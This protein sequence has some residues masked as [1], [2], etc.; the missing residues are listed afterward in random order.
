MIYNKYFPGAAAI[1]FILLL[2]NAGCARKISRNLNSDQTT[3]D[4]V[5][6][7]LIGNSFS[8]NATRFLPQLASEG[9]HGLVIGRAE[10]GSCS[11]QRHWESVVAAEADSTSKKGKPYKG[12]SLRM[13]LSEG[14]WDIVTIQQYSM[15][16][17]DTSTYSPFAEKLV[18]FIKSIQPNAEVVFHQTWAYRSDATGFGLISKGRYAKSS[19]EMWQKISTASEK[20]SGNLGIRVI[21]TGEAFWKVDSHKKWGYKKDENYNFKN[22]TYPLLPNQ[23]YSLHV[24]YNWGKAELPIK[25][26]SHHAS[27]AG[28]YL[29]GLVWYSF[30]F[31]ESPANLQ[32]TPSEVSA[33]F[34]KFLKVVAN[35]T[36]RN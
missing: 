26:D 30:L 35:S 33:P 21:P 36:L 13:L 20:I 3:R 12:K 27:V 14:R 2:L 28:C 8:Q 9:G 24:G 22:P 23:D 11:F 25:F 1:F 34:G 17:G 19:E 18:K 15:Y 6:L 7:F 4:S 10:L 29:A 31:N 5:R 16:S 32:F